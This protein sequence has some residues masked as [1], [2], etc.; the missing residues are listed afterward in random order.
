MIQIV[1]EEPVYLV[2]ERFRVGVRH[3][4][5]R[6]KGQKCRKRLRFGARRAATKRSTGALRDGECERA[7]LGRRGV[8]VIIYGIFLSEMFYQYLSISYVF[9]MVFTCFH[10]FSHCF[11][12][13][14]YRF[15]RVLGLP[16]PQNRL[17]S[18]E[19]VDSEV[20]WMPCI[21][22]AP[23]SSRCFSSC[24]EACFGVPRASNQHV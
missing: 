20:T 24:Q 2:K 16:R 7:L 3:V 10:A 12:P 22:S 17:D 14:F 4:F 18:G 6:F 15:E 9:S 23:R 5:G 11:R 8:D 1:S 19:R 13:L 21:S